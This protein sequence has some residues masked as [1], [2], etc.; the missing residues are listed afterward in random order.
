MDTQIVYHMIVEDDLGNRF[1]YKSTRQGTAPKGC[2]C[3]GVC[4]FHERRKSCKKSSTAKKQ[5][6]P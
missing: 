5:G 4:G 3:I 1:E 6:K 2:R